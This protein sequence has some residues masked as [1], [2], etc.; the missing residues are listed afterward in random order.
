[1]T[2][3][4]LITAALL[5]VPPGTSS[6]AAQAPA[7]QPADDLQIIR[8][9]DARAKAHPTAPDR[10]AWWREARFGM[11]IHWGLFSI[12]AG[13]WKGREF[14]GKY[15]EHIMLY[16][17]IP[18]RE[19]AKLADE[20]N[21]RRFDANEWTGLAKRAGMRYLVF[22]TKHQDGFAMFDS[23]ASDFDVID[24]TPF[25]RD[26]AKELAEAA[27]SRG[28]KMGFYYSHARDHHHPLANWNKYG[29]TWDF[30][31]RTEADF[32]RYLD[33][34]AKPQIREL[35]SHYGDIG[36]MWFDVPY[37]IPPDQSN[38]IVDMVHQLQPGCLVN[39][40]VGG[41][42]W[43]Y[44]SL[45]DNQISHAALGEPWETC[46]TINDSWGFHS[47]DHN[48]KS[49]AQIIRHLAD[50][51]SKGGNLLLNIG[52]KADGTIPEESVRCLEEVGRWMDKNG[53]SIHGASASPIGQP[54]WGR[55][56]VKGKN[57]YM[58]LFDWPADG[59]LSAEGLPAKVRRVVLLG[60]AAPL[61]FTANDRSVTILLPAKP[62]D[63]AHAVIALELAE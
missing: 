37:N 30:P 10:I 61:K 18:M 55:C 38:G 16:G 26:P 45:G 40:R 9:N 54:T 57:L 15:A 51:V 56:T 12:P 58:H 34:K 60:G 25:K 33:E 49:Y 59:S 42:M 43:D 19:Y 21:P 52:P 28:L 3:R 53:E 35:L 5:L 31:P 14:K 13:V 62:D 20:F 39:S 27:R 47:L 24:A 32:I 50:I 1:M 36:V 11:F 22:V 8:E 63:L 23:K 6:A 17:K 4:S 7:D 48:W 44:R 46:M 41:E 2:P 29:N